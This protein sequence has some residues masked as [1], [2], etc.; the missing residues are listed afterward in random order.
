MAKSQLKTV[1]HLKGLAAALEEC[2]EEEQAIRRALSGRERGGI[3]E[4]VVRAAED[5]QLRDAVD[6]L[7][8]QAEAKAHEL[9]RAEGDDDDDDDDEIDW[10]EVAFIA[11]MIFT[12]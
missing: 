3:V 12:L 7:R 10:Q 2:P 11:I 8:S 1:H 5:R 9:A 4:H 6:R